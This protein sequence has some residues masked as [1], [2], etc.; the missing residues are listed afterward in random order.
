MALKYWLPMTDG[1]LHNQGVSNITLTNNNVTSNSN[2]K[3]GKCVYFNGSAAAYADGITVGNNLTVC[4]WAKANT[5]HSGY[6]FQL[7]NAATA[8]QVQVALRT[9]ASNQQYIAFIGNTSFTSGYNIGCNTTDWNH[10]CMV[11]EET[12]LRIYINGT[13]KSSH[14]ISSYY[15]GH[16]LSLGQYY[17]GTNFNG[18]I[19][20]FR[21]YDNV[22]SPSDIKRISQ[23]LVLHYSLSNRGF[24]NENLL[25]RYVTPGQA[26]PTSTATAGRTKYY[27]D[28]GI[29]IPAQESADT[30]FRL[31]LKEKLTLNEVYTI[32]CQASGL[33]NG[34]YIRFPLFAQGNTSMGI[35]NIDHNGLCSLTFTMTYTNQ[36]AATA[37]S[38][39]VYICFLD[40][41]GRNYVSGQG[42][43]TL[44][45]FKIEKG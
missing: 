29:I 37:G 6:I 4:F 13:Y 3:L 10:Y 14:T 39:T 7:G 25:T 9:E 43:I 34:S 23:G 20:D 12:T 16:R 28:Y 40:D 35:L 1:T 30:Y 8:N 24:G 17:S 19:N 18:Y 33:L 5:V 15:S 11:I 22:L 31:F 32:S 41:S 21:L 26:S 45:N 44:T 38:E 27:G 36:T 2:G 42:T